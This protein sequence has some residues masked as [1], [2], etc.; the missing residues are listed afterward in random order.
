M[1]SG[2]RSKLAVRE[3]TLTRLFV[4]ETPYLTLFEHLMKKKKSVKSNQQLGWWRANPQIIIANVING[5][6]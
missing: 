5:T 2:E 3:I 4:K 6:M 1:D